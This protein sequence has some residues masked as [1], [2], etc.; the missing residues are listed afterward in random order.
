MPGRTQEGPTLMAKV[1]KSLLVPE[2]LN[3]RLSQLEQ[4]SGATFTRVAIAALLQ[5]LYSSPE[6]EGPDPLWM[7]FAVKLDRGE[8]TLDALHNEYARHLCERAIP[9]LAR[10]DGLYEAAKKAKTPQQW[11]AVI[12]EHLNPLIDERDELRVHR[13]TEAVRRLRPLVEKGGK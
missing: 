11:H 1:Q 4:R 3:K 2:D 12:T 8:I 13:L 5:Y 10:L 7:E 6:D 9:Y